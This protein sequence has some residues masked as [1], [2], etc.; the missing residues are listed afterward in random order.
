MTLTRRKKQRSYE[1]DIEEAKKTVFKCVEIMQKAPSIKQ[2][3]EKK[4]KKRTYNMFDKFKASRTKRKQSP[5]STATPN[6]KSLRGRK[7]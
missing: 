2:V 4:Q 7:V 6:V 3:A 5:Q 1:D